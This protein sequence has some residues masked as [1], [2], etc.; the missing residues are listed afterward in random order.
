MG[1]FKIIGDLLPSI[2]DK[3]KE[4]IHAPL[5]EAL[6]ESF[7]EVFSTI[8]SHAAQTVIGRFQK[9]LSFTISSMNDNEKEITLYNI[10]S[11]YNDFSKLAKLRMHN[12]D[13]GTHT[14]FELLI[15]DGCHTIRY[16]KWQLIMLVETNTT[17]EFY[18]TRKYTLITYDLNN[19]FIKSFK[20]DFAETYKKVT[21]AQPVDANFINVHVYDDRGE[22]TKIFKIPKRNESTLYISEDLK[23]K[24]FKSIDSFMA[25]KE[26][27]DT[28]SI[29]RNFKI[30]LYGPPGTGKDTI[31][32]VIASKYDRTLM[33]FNVG[34]RT[35]DK[36]NN[37]KSSIHKPLVLLSDIDRW[38]YLINDDPKV[39]KQEMTESKSL[40]GEM[41]NV[42][43][44][45]ISANN[46]KIII[47]TTN[48]IDLFS[49]S[50]IRPGR[51][52]LL[53]E[54]GYVNEEV[55][56]K[57]YK[58][59][60]HEELPNDIT[61]KDKVTV[62]AMQVDVLAGISKEEFLIKYIK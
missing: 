14:E 22:G 18:T 50:F 43:D 46:D 10:L 58:E 12:F 25:K 36:I 34:K 53:L 37:I 8:G 3:L 28:H 27:Y 38:P 45:V 30:L 16:K 20:E 51:I 49:P 59:H 55:F 52:D 6:T 4:I 48:N 56:K 44:G 26:Y 60:F 2:N 21:S 15:D 61:V 41:I 9:S 40:Y 31:A 62:S 54:I 39:P 11:K 5:N 33:Y 24:I 7:K 29:P 57:Y 42:L 17:S 47:I 13:T 1:N 32:R 19:E 23:R 35:P